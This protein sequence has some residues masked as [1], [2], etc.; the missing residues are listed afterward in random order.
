MPLPLFY[1]FALMMLAGGICVVALPNPV[2][3]ALSM[4]G[5]FIGLAALLIGLNAYFVGTLQVLV[6]AGAIMVL[7]LFIIMLLDLKQETRKKFSPATLAVSIIVPLILVFQ[8]MTVI[9]GREGSDEFAKLDAE[10]LPIAAKAVVEHNIIPAHSKIITDLNQGELPD[11]NIIGQKLFTDYN[12]PLQMVGFLLLVATV[13]CICLSKKIERKPAPSTPQVLPKPSIAL[14]KT[15]Q[16]QT[17]PSKKKDSPSLSEGTTVVNK[18]EAPQ[19][20]EK[21]EDS[22][23]KE[24][25]VTNKEEEQ[26]K[27]ED[28]KGDDT[29]LPKEGKIDP[30]LGFVYSTAPADVDDLKVIS[31]IGAVI[32]KKLNGFGVYTYQQIAKWSPEIISEFDSL[33]S[34]KGRIERDQWLTQAKE[35]HHKKHNA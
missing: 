9:N 22:T 28:S 24:T 5:S 29:S 1:L 10:T 7:F 17:A 18:E 12:F 4:I 6:Y 23:S 20:E 19:K 15:N 11:V 21:K 13:G 3:S 14:E 27:E 30:T 2:S 35:L 16:A 34:F 32:E 25:A 26:T 33:L 8:I 31:G